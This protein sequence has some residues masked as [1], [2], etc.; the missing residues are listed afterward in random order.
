MTAGSV[1]SGIVGVIFFLIGV[2]ASKI[3]G[4][5]SSYVLTDAIVIKGDIKTDTVRSGNRSYRTYFDI[6]YDVEY[7]VAGKKYPGTVSDRFNSFEQAKTTLDAAKGSIKRL[8]YDPNDPT[9][10]SVSKNTESLVRWGAF[11]MSTLLL[12]YA[13]MTWILRDNTALCALTTLGNI[14]NY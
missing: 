13:V 3:V 7:E 2:F 11:G 4:D 5:T 14:R 10:N 8:Y 1:V 12:G 6:V 9:Q